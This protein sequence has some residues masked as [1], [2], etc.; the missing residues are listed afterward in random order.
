MVSWIPFAVLL[1]S[2]PIE[3]AGYI[4]KYL[5]QQYCIYIHYKVCVKAGHGDLLLFFSFICSKTSPTSES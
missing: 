1:A 5:V 2:R 3:E 4:P